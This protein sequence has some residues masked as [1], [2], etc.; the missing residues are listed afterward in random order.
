M[1]RYFMTFLAIFFPWV[2]L[3]AKDNPGGALI[4][5]ALQGSVIGWI[6]A[7]IWAL[8]VINEDEKE[9]EREK[10]RKASS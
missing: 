8:K 10:Y 3:F 5:L 2:V 6:P 1:F 7:S 9:K 4:A